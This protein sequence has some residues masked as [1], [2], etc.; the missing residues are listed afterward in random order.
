MNWHIDGSPRYAIFHPCI[1]QTRGTGRLNYDTLL[2]RLDETCAHVIERV[3]RSPYVAAIVI[4]VLLSLAYLPGVT[5]L[6]GVDRT[7]PMIAA[8]SRDVLE[9]GDIWRPAYNGNHLT[10]RPIAVFWSQALGAWFSERSARN[11]ITRYRIPSFLASIAAALL[12]YWLAAPLVASAAAFAAS[13]LV[14]LTPVV[15]LHAQLSIVEPLFPALD[16]SCPIRSA[17]RLSVS[18]AGRYT[19]PYT[20]WYNGLGVALL[21]RQWA[22]PVL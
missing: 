5:V 18:I 13:L 14:G 6:P 4:A 11:E 17:A 22:Q 12:F 20:G 16:P 19:G 15:A 21:D 3:T 1:G 7:E 2:A 8:A 10:T 9:T